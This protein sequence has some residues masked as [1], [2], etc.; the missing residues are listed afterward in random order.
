MKM[1]KQKHHKKP[2][3]KG[4]VNGN[5][6]SASS[7]PI[8]PTRNSTRRRKRNMNALSADDYKLRQEIE[9]GKSNKPK[10]MFCEP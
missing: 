3:K 4:H 9:G 6:H 1:G 5:E 10:L 8:S 7:T 2:N